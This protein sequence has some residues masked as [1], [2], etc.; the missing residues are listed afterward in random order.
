MDK[1]SS[2][3]VFADFAED[4]QLW[5]GTVDVLAELDCLLSLAAVSSN[6]IGCVRPKFVS[7]EASGGNSF[8][9]L[10]Q[11]VHPALYESQMQKHMDTQPTSFIP[12]D[13]VIGT[14]DCPA[15]FVLVSGPNMGGQ[16][17]CSSTALNK[18]SFSC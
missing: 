6:H 8:I 16:F 17:S 18:H 9:D 11:A 3:K 15:K 13:T 7:H 2:R 12:N 1:D 10:R 14:G 4:Y 5:S